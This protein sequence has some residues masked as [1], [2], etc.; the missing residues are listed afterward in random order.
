MKK[1]FLIASALLL[2]IVGSAF[3]VSDQKKPSSIRPVTLQWFVFNGAPGEENIESE[4]ELVSMDPGCSQGNK[5]CAVYAQQRVGSS[6]AVPNL[7]LQHDIYTK[8]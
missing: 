5:R 3:V 8:P 4:Y 7:S 6:P 2:L 1:Y